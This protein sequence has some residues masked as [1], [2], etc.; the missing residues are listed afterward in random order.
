[1]TSTFR[2]GAARRGAAAGFQYLIGTPKRLEI[3][4][5]R[6]KQNFEVISNRDKNATP[7]KRD[8]TT[9][10]RPASLIVAPETPFEAQ[11][12]QKYL[13]DGAR[14]VKKDGRSKQRPYERDD[15]KP[16]RCR[17]EA[18]RHTTKA[19]RRGKNVARG[20]GVA[21][22]LRFRHALHAET[23]CHSR[24]RSRRAAARHARSRGVGLAIS[25]FLREG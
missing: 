9:G 18:R 6:T 16:Q 10:H 23:D 17:A 1:M 7:A 11:G 5:T 8:Q 24:A 20:G 15:K 13:A 4:A 3:G 14:K 2:N 19:R 22:I 12:R 21:Y 25:E